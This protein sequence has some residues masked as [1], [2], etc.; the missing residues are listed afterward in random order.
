MS[1]ERFIRGI[2]YVVGVEKHHYRVSLIGLQGS[3]VLSITSM[4][5]KPAFFLD[6][7]SYYNF[8]ED[9]KNIYGLTDKIP[10]HE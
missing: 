6:T 7:Q 9:R 5:F 8:M 4:T 2:K 3:G 10:F 1:K